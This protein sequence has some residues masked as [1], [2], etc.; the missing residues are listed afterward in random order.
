MTFSPL[1]ETPPVPD[2]PG[3]NTEEQRWEE[4]F[5]VCGR[6]GGGFGIRSLGFTGLGERE[7]ASKRLTFG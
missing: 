7:R 4:V 2:V 3:R 1:K 6:G 5:A